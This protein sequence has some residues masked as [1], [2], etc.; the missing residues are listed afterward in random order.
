MP[1]AGAGDLEVGAEGLNGFYS[2]VRKVRS[3]EEFFL[4]SLFSTLATFLIPGTKHTTKA[5]QGSAA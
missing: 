4:Q 1:T 2:A 5:T 3:L